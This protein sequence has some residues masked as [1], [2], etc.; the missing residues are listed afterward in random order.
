MTDG[1]DR[2]R[3]YLLFLA[4]LQ[5]GP[6]LRAK[7]DVE[8]VVQQTLVEAWQADAPVNGRL[9]WLRRALA[10]NLADEFRRLRADKRDAGRERSLEAA[11]DAS[12]ARLGGMLAA[13]QSS[14][15][16]RVVRD[17]AAL[18]VVE[19]LAELPDAQRDALVLQHWQGWPLARIGDHLGR[20]PAAVAGLIKRGLKRLRELLGDEP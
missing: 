19:A 18:R 3:R 14:P 13:D 7:L 12:S 1:P 9:P 8:G 17:E 16:G 11:L 4:G 2:Y 10:R 6:D 20:T 15:S 5:V